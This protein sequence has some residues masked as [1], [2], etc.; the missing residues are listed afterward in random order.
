MPT[1]VNQT[2]AIADNGSAGVATAGKTYAL[3]TPPE[4]VIAL[5]KAV[6]E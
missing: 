4:N 3:G 5:I 1:S 6:H 2:E